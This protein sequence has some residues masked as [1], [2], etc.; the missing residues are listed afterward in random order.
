MVGR[1]NALKLIEQALKHSPGDQTEVLLRGEDSYLTR[2]AQ[3]HIHQNVGEKD[4]TVAVRVIMGKKIGSASANALDEGSVRRT[5]EKAAE[6]ARLQREN[7][8]FKSLPGPSPVPEVD[9][10]SPRTAEM[11]PEDRAKAVEAVIARAKKKGFEAAGAFSTGARELAVGN[12]LGVR[13]YHAG[14]SAS[15]VTVAMS[16]TSSGYAEENS[17]DASQIDPG[18]VADVAVKKC[19]DSVESAKVEPGEYEVIL[20]ELA[21]FNLVNYLSRLGFSALA[22]QEG[23]SFLVGRLG[24]KIVGESITLWDDGLDPAGTVMPFDFEGVPK[25]KLMLIEN[26]VAKNVVYDSYTAGREPGKKSTGHATPGFY[27]SFGPAP[28]NLFLKPGQASI[29]DMIKSTKRG[30]LVTR[31]HYTNPIHPVKTIITGMTRDGTFLIENG[32][33]KGAVKNFRFTQSVLEAFSNV[34]MIGRTPKLISGFFGG[35]SVPALKVSRF[36]FT[37]VTEF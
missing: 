13:A 2:F 22:L 34:E 18:A 21:V 37:G 15:L 20:E 6:I 9:G 3:S 8:D 14:T 1:E 28:M 7:P 12:S 24:Q 19:A 10:F 32:M 11:S 35:S 17:A 5:V 33:V 30:I 25:Q 16:P 26:G 29:E 4:A 31:F 36:N 23:R 27:G